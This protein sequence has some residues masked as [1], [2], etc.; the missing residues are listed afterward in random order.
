MSDKKSSAMGSFKKPGKR[1]PPASKTGA[2]AD[3]P[4]EPPA[5]KAQIEWK[6]PFRPLLFHESPRDAHKDEVFV[7]SRIEI[8][9][10]PGLWAIR[11]QL[12]QSETKTASAAAAAKKKK[13]TRPL[14]PESLVDRVTVV[15]RARIHPIVLRDA[16]PSP[17]VLC[18]LV[19]TLF[20]TVDEL[21]QCMEMV[22][23]GGASTR[24]C[25]YVWVLRAF[26][27]DETGKVVRRDFRMTEPELTAM[28][29][30]NRD[31]TGM[32][33]QLFDR[34]DRTNPLIH[35]CANLFFA[36]FRGDHRTQTPSPALYFREVLEHG[37]RYSITRNGATMHKDI[38]MIP[39]AF[40]LSVRYLDEEMRKQFVEEVWGL[41]M[42]TP[43]AIAS[44]IEE[45]EALSVKV[46]DLKPGRHD[47]DNE[48]WAEDPELDVEASLDEINKSFGEEPGTRSSARSV[49]LKPP[50][51]PITVRETKKSATAADRDK[52]AKQ[53]QRLDA[54]IYTVLHEYRKASSALGMSQRRQVT[55]INMNDVQMALAVVTK[56]AIS[57]LES[58][59]V[60]TSLL[61]RFTQ[62]GVLLKYRAAQYSATMHPLQLP[63]SD[64]EGILSMLNADEWALHSGMIRHPEWHEIVGPLLLFAPFAVSGT[65]AHGPATGANQNPLL[66]NLMNALRLKLDTLQ[67]AASATADVF[68]NIL[69]TAGLE[70]VIHE[71]EVALPTCAAPKPLI[72]ATGLAQTLD[73]TKRLRRLE[74]AASALIQLGDE[75]SQRREAAEAKTRSEEQSR[76]RL[77]ME[78]TDREEAQRLEDLLAASSSSSSSVAHMTGD[79]DE[80]EDG[81]KSLDDFLTEEADNIAMEI[82]TES[83]EERQVERD[84]DGNVKMYD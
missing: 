16:F 61:A 54:D 22:A 9:S 40:Y 63:D 26:W 53:R 80:Q 83:T 64:V 17:D 70:H 31:P 43:V 33:D 67:L 73:E 29:G 3:V 49:Y 66:Q 25:S 60:G 30:H 72:T 8:L 79:S 45:P 44:M 34:F 14:V 50:A 15:R 12:Q 68:N 2:A 20:I 6:Q 59:P 77:E 75:A 36:S 1:K 57:S 55:A 10:E 71:T 69:K 24:V 19:Q 56:F 32:Y 37:N 38:P 4:D 28:P 58:R 46:V 81:I 21:A 65:C 27:V 78:R 35:A 76:Q 84:A 7:G 47:P 13:N 42:A 11:K 18:Q 48:Y 82:N 41:R 23:G 62:L 74:D 51:P 52:E 39:P 5:K